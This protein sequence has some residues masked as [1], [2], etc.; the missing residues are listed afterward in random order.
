MDQRTR[1]CCYNTKISWILINDYSLG[2]I[3]TL[4]VNSM[5]E[6]IIQDIDTLTMN[7]IQDKIR[8]DYDGVVI[9]TEINSYNMFE[10]KFSN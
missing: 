4:L 3:Y 7:E 2:T 8:A 5:C 6:F 9:N 1:D 10:V